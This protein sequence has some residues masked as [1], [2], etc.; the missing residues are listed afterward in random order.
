L[1]LAR[2]D[3]GRYWAICVAKGFGQIPGKDFQVNHAPL[4]SDTTLH[5]LM[6]IK[7]M[8]K[9]EAGKFDIETAFLYG[10]L[11]EDLWMAIPEGYERYVKEKT[12]EEH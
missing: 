11:E 6:V 8:L 3:D 4:V 12:Q 9:L 5:L 10:K 2:K 1:L 7:T